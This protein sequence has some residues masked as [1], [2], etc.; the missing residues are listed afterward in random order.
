[1][2]KPQL[3]DKELAKKIVSA[4]DEELR[5]LYFRGRKR[6]VD[7]RDAMAHAA[8]HAPRDEEDDQLGV[9]ADLWFGF[10]ARCT[11]PQLFAYKELSYRDDV[12]ERE[13]G[14]GCPAYKAVRVYE[15]KLVTRAFKT[16]RDLFP[17]IPN[18][19]DRHRKRW[20][21]AIDALGLMPPEYGRAYAASVTA[22]EN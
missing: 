18:S 19:N 1:M 20:E 2:K 14:E 5:A 3:T 8:K 4:T 17:V 22:P 13:T 10:S 21:Q 6:T 15:K 9:S 12:A 7:L 11:R 16:L